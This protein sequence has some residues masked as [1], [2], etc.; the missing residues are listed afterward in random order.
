MYETEIGIP[1]H[2]AG[3][4]EVARSGEIWRLFQEVAMRATTAAGWPPAA[5]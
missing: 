2:G 4:R 3:P 1:R 5:P